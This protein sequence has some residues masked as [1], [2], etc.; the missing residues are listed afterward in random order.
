MSDDGE[1]FQEEAPTLGVYEGE[2]NE[3]K[4]RHGKGKNTFPNGDVYEGAYENGQRHGTGAYTWKNGARYSGEYKANLR[5][6]HGFFVY[7][8]GSKYKGDK[9]CQFVEGKR[10]GFGTYVYANS[11]VYNGEW[12]NDLKDGEGVYTY[13]SG[14]KKTGVWSAGVLNGPGEIIHADHKV[15]GNWLSN[16]K[17][18]VP[19]KIVF[20]TGFVK[21]VWDQNVPKVK[22]FLP[23]LFLAFHYALSVPMLARVH[24]TDGLTNVTQ[25][26]ID[27]TERRLHLVPNHP[28]N[29]LKRRIEGYFQ[30]AFPQQFTIHDSLNPVVTPKQNFD[31]LL[32]PT[33]HPSRKPTDTYYI[34]SN[35]MLRTHT[36][37]HQSDILK[38]KLSDGYLLT[39]DVYRRDEI[40]TSH[41]PVFHQMEGI[42]TFPR[43]NLHDHVDKSLSILNAA[44]KTLKVADCELSKT[45]FIQKDHTAED[46]LVVGKHL[47]QSLEGM[48]LALFPGNRD[49][50]IRWIEGYFPFTS[51]SWE[52]EVLYQGK[53]LE[54]CGCGVI[55]HQILKDAGVSFS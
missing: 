33:D 37:A 32:I 26:I 47:K 35:F 27:K 9:Q 44:K 15:T 28:L 2:R 21:E 22:P 4:Q 14:S 25:S 53:W 24:T 38:T 8:D 7:P 55:Q 41:Y 16:E 54:L 48:V 36:S 51:P 45:N 29:I 12:K 20:P 19:A 6:G 42:L 5:D 40:D 10:H 49:L 11:D 46:A 39:A 30:S 43:T 34:N 13:S 17:M 23:A 18:A 50:Q 3:Q 1:E 31:D 52:L